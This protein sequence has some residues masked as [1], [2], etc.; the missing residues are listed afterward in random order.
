MANGEK[1]KRY[2]SVYKQLRAYILEHHLQPGDVLPTEQELCELYG[3]SRNILREALKGLSVLGVI[4]GCPGRGN[5]VQ[6][7]SVE[8]LMSNVL[9]CTARDSTDI[10][11]QLL[12]VRKKLELAYMREAY[13]TLT[14]AD[15]QHI[16]ATLERIKSEWERNVYFHADD[17]EF[18]MALFA[19]I[20]NDALHAIFSCIWDLDEHFQVAKKIAAHGAHHRQARKHRPRPRTAQPRGLRG[21]HACPLLLR[22]I[23]R[24]HQRQRLNVRRILRVLRGRGPFCRKAPSLALPPGKTRIERRWGR[25]RFS[26]RSASP[27]DPLSRRAVGVWVA[28]FLLLGSA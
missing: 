16:R 2:T 21:C 22:Q 6:P 18:H 28:P 5:V 27:P 25:G 8:D 3:V 20:N 13:Q 17:R 12:D 19:H 23:R 9:F 24:R 7:F 1:E 15:I 4:K 10:L 26:E 14:M 11:T